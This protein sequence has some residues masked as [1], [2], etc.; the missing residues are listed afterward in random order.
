[1]DVEG[2]VYIP[3]CFDELMLEYWGRGAQEVA[4]QDAVP[5]EVGGAA[6]GDEVQ[7]GLSPIDKG[8][9]AE[10]KMFDERDIVVYE[11][12]EW[13]L[14]VESAADELIIEYFGRTDPGYFKL[15]GAGYFLRCGDGYRLEGG[16]GYQE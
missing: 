9:I 4:R 2:N 11:S 7:A 6:S 16:D 12:E 8:V 1:V 15:G 13:R 5:S 14:A 10:D 3:D